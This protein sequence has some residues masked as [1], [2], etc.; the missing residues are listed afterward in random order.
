LPLVRIESSP[1]VCEVCGLKCIRQSSVQLAIQGVVGSCEKQQASI[2]FP[3]AT[4]PPP[5]R[6]LR[7]TPA[8]RGF[9]G[10]NALASHSAPW[11]ACRAETRKEGGPATGGPAS[12]SPGVDGPVPARKRGEVPRRVRVCSLTPCAF[13]AAC[14]HSRACGAFVTMFCSLSR[15][16]VPC[17][18]KGAATR[19]LMG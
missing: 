1:V 5:R 3:T 19:G 6:P 2:P 17:S 13:G 14:G 16:G 12:E 10:A 7:S 15:S 8:S 9:M 4:Y 18:G 11:E